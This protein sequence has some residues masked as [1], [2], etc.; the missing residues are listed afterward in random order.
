MLWIP[1]EGILQGD[2]WLRHYEPPVIARI[3]G[4]AVMLDMRTLRPG[5]DKHLA[6]ALI[7]IA[8]AVRE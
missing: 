3:T 1:N 8:R 7:Q 4:D 2:M 6:S 5:E